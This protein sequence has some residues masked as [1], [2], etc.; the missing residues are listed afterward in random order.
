VTLFHLLDPDEVEL[1][2]DELE[3]TEFEGIEPEDGRRLLVDPRDLA[4]S[5]ARESLALRERWRLACL[6]AQVEYRF[7]TTA[8]PPSEVLRAFLFDRQRARR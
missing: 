8:T 3:L 6:E 5:F 1:P 7:A 4:A 2:I